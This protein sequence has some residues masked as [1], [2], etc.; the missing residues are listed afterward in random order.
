M[1]VDTHTRF[2]I[3]QAAKKK[4]KEKEKQLLAQEEKAR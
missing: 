2:H 1:Y 4:E 3:Q